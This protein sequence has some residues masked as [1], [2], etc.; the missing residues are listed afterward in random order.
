M[1][2]L[3][4][5]PAYNSRYAPLGLMKISS[6]LKRQEHEIEFI[7]GRKIINYQP[8]KIYITTLFTFWYKITIETIL[9]YK[10]HYPN[11]EILIG[12]IFA[13]LMGEFILNQT[14]IKPYFGLMPEVEEVPPDYS[15]SASN[16]SI[17]FTSRG[18]IRKCKFCIVPKVE[19][20][21]R[22]V[23]NWERSID[24]KKPFIT[25]WDN[26]WFAKDFE[27]LKDDCNK[28]GELIKQGV[29]SFDFNQ[30]LDARLFNEDIAELLKG[31][32][33]KPIR[34]AFDNMSQDGYVQNAIDLSK[35]YG[36][37]RNQKWDAGCGSQCMIYVLYN[38]MDTPG[39]FYYR[40]KEILKHGAT[41]Y[42]MQF[43]PFTD[44]NRE[45]IGKYWTEVQR[46]AVDS[47]TNN[48]GQISCHSREEFEY[49]WGKN[50][51]EFMNIISNPNV[52][53]LNQKRIETRKIA[54]IRKKL[55]YQSFSN[56]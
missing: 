11:S 7:K 23:E 36:F 39:D 48:M 40:I 9:F 18:C 17:C 26:N 28:I 35:K 29:K 20:G 32:P 8:D 47:L 12:G 4:I 49:Y 15:L 30:G 22:N 46:N 5:E 53:K 14:K 34:F 10:K 38:F 25:F 24:V 19:G 27:V 6:Y 43:H 1:K 37:I 52:R 21:L 54:N 55:N 13:S 33:I 16:C 50:E 2:I 31:L 45:H 3:L 56:I 42:P 44:L 51:K 41:S